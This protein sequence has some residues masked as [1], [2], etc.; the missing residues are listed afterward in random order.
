MGGS[1]I[2]DGSA[3]GRRRG[4]DAPPISGVE[5]VVGSNVSFRVMFLTMLLLLGDFVC[6]RD[7]NESLD[8]AMMFSSSDG[9]GY[10]GGDETGVAHTRFWLG[11]GCKDRFDIPEDNDG[12]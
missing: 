3:E 4:K 5:M 2:E 11:E 7:V 1:E 6:S 9:V 8:C 12:C 10:F